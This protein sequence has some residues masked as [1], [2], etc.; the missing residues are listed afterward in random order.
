MR[1]GRRA[2]KGRVC[3][4]EFIIPDFIFVIPAEAGIQSNNRVA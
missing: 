1:Q 4:V 3:W 2:R